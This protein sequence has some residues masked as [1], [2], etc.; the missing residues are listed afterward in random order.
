MTVQDSSSPM[1]MA[2]DDVQPRRISGR[3]GFRKRGNAIKQKHIRA[4]GHLPSDADNHP[5]RAKNRYI[6][7]PAEMMPPD[8]GPE[9][10]DF[11]AVMARHG[12]LSMK[13]MERR[14]GITGDTLRRWMLGCPGAKR[15]EPPPAIWTVFRY[16]DEIGRA[17]YAP[18]EPPSAMDIDRFLDRHGLTQNALAA[19]LTVTDSSVS[20]WLRGVS[21][22]KRWVWHILDLCDLKAGFPVPDRPGDPDPQVKRRGRKSDLLLRT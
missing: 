19:I 3:G 8:H 16:W 9:L 15:Q 2:F 17:P 5:Y 12:I 14:L 18:A 1:T 6:P 22:P 4:D 7:A 21:R 20:F 11:R 13:S 10:E